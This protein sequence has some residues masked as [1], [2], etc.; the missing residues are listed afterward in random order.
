MSRKATMKFKRSLLSIS[1]DS[2]PKRTRQSSIDI[3][4]V[5]SDPGM[6]LSGPTSG[7]FEVKTGEVAN[8][9]KFKLEPR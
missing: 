2:S 1:D 7:D 4:H 6:P 8:Q 9:D 5:V 3:E